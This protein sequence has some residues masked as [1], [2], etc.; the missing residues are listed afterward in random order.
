[1]GLDSLTCEQA[2][3]NGGSCQRCARWTA[4]PFASG[5]KTLVAETKQTVRKIR[6]TSSAAGMSW[7][8]SERS[9][10]NREISLSERPYERR[11]EFSHGLQ[12][13]RTLSSAR[14][15]SNHPRPR[16]EAMPCSGS[17]T[18]SGNFPLAQNTS[19]GMPPRGYQYPPTRR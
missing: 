18:P 5:T 19:I 14:C 9:T 1:M 15:A 4:P 13:V 2:C 10:E 16:N 8:V 11:N 7:S 6:G 3:L 17:Q 12:D